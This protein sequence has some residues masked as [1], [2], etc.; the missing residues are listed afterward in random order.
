MLQ[1]RTNYRQIM[2]LTVTENQVAAVNESR[3]K[4]Q[5]DPKCILIVCIG[6]L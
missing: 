6:C 5:S 3:V 4:V 1:K 2:P